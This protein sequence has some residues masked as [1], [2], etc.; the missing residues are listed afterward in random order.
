MSSEEDSDCSGTG[1]SS[2]SSSTSSD[3]ESASILRKPVFVK[4]SK[5]L[6]LNLDPQTKPG[7]VL[8]KAEFQQNLELKEAKQEDFDGVTDTDDLD[9]EAEFEAWKERERL[10]KVRDLEKEAKEENGEGDEGQEGYSSRSGAFYQDIDE[11]LLKRD[12]GEVVDQGDHSRPT[13]FKIAK[14]N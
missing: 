13:K 9:P 8:A 12:V 3:S 14:G 11:K 1:S 6:A 2:D 5:K 7:N 10:R 4:K